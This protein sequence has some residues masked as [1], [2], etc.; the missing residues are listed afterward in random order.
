MKSDSFIG[1]LIMGRC[2]SGKRPP[3]FSCIGMEL[4][5]LAAVVVVVVGPTLDELLLDVGPSTLSVVGASADDDE[6][7]GSGTLYGVDAAD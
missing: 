7:G 3:V 4:L 6:E 5:L 2:C 1:W